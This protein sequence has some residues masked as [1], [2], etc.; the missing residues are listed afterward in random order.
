MPPLGDI[1][2]RGLV[3]TC[4]GVSVYGCFLGYAVHRDTLRRG[5]GSPPYC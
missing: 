1:L 4:A 3:L 2:H 5:Q